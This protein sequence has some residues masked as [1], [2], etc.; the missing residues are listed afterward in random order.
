[1][2]SNLTVL[3]ALTLLALVGVSGCGED[4]AADNTRDDDEATTDDDTD[5]DADDDTTQEEAKDARVPQGS[6]DASTK[7]DASTVKRDA[8]SDGGKTD[9]AVVASDAGVVEDA[10]S[11]ADAG[12]LDAGARD[13]GRD[14]GRRRL[15]D[16]I[17]LPGIGRR[18]G[19]FRL[20]GLGDGID[21][22]DLGGGIDLPDLPNFP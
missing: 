10:G 16:G 6:V 21:L 7:L 20:P 19:G 13:A 2:R 8:G 4:E 22:P 5:D 12:V 15:G 18:D 14:G 3:F 1:M 9:G 17:D 11:T